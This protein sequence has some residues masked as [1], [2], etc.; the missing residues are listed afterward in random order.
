VGAGPLFHRLASLIQ[1]QRQFL[2]LA[3][4]VNPFESG[5]RTWEELAAPIAAAVRERQ[6]NGPYFL[7]GWCLAGVLAYEVARQLEHAGETVELVALLD[8]PNPAVRQAWFAAAPRL[9]WL[10]LMAIKTRFHISEMLR[11]N[12]ATLPGYLAARLRGI[13][14]Q[15][16]TYRLLRRSL[17]TDSG[18]DVPLDFDLAFLDLAYTYV[19][20][21]IQARVAQFRPARRA[22]G[23]WLTDGLGWESLGIDLE[24]IRVPGEHREMLMAPNVELVAREISRLLKK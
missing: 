5:V 16:E 20:G 21:P 19:P 4:P 6:P 7:G 11:R 2:S 22:R 17:N 15:R 23:A 10:Q 1:P 13:V 14:E 8:S 3:T 18:I 24:V 9:R 12:P